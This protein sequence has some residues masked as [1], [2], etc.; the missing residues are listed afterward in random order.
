LKIKGKEILD[1]LKLVLAGKTFDALLPP[2]I[3]VVVNGRFGLT[4]ATIVSVVA[5]LAFGIFRL[6]KKQAWQYAFGGLI[7]VVIAS[8]FAYFAG[9]AINYFIPD[10]IGSVF[11]LIIALTSLIIGKPLAAWTSHL[12]RGWA[13]KWYWREDVKPAYKEV[14]WFWTAFFLVRVVIQIL[15]Y[16]GENIVKLTWANTLLGLPVTI[17]VLVVSYVYGIW[18]LRQLGG[19]GV[20]EFLEGNA[21]P[22]KGQT[23]G[24]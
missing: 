24:F 6:I 7:G 20:E 19:P 8:G 23:R 18:R 16:L 4:M 1:E 12:T 17:L 22:W 3:F 2:L 11:L 14:T 5:A 13:L 9:N 21:P 15:L 10:I